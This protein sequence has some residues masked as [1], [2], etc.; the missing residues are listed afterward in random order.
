MH[1]VDIGAMSL[2]RTQSPG[3]ELANAAS[4]GIGLMLAIA[5]LPVLVWQAGHMGE[6][7]D[8]VGASVF[9]GTMILLYLVST[10]YHALPAGRAKAWAKRIDHA[11]IYVF[12]AGSYTPFTLGV[13]QGAWGWTLFGMVWTMAAVGVVA[14]LT[15]RLRHRWLSTGLYVAMGW[16]VIIA[17]APLLERVP[18][19]GLALLAAGGACYTLGALVFLCDHRV[20]YAHFAW[21]LLVL[22]G[23]ACHFFA[24][25]GYAAA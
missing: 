24:A 3:E 21:H 13:L 17:I 18:W 16:T 23:T 1:L 5:A 25:L 2:S 19:P 11:A 4:H 7:V 8:V 6:P 12:I 22:G 15:H 9:A 14:K 10:V 20:R